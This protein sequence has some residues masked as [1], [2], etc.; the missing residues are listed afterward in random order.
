[1]CGGQLKKTTRVSKNRN[2]GRTQKETVSL[3][4]TKKQNCQTYQFILKGNQF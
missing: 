4:C 3:R 1:M 2:L